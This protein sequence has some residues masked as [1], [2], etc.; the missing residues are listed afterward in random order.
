[1]IQEPRV[2]ISVP[3]P[4]LAADIA[5]LD[6]ADRVEC[7]T[8]DLTTPSPS[9][10]IELVVLP[11]QQDPRLV[12]NLGATTTQ[13]VQAQTIGY[14]DIVAHLPP[15]HTVAN[16]RSVH[17]ASTAEL[18]LG[19]ALASLRR[20]PEYSIAA[21]GGRWQQLPGQSL[22]DRTVA[23]VGYGGV[24]QAIEKRLDGF[25]ARVLRFARTARAGGPGGA[26]L[27]HPISSLRGLL[28][29]IDV[30]ILTVPLTEETRHLV[31]DAFLAAMRPG[32]LLV[33]VAR[34]PVVDTD[35]LV[36]ALETGHIRA[37]LDVTDPEPLPPEHPLWGLEG[38]LITPHVGGASSAMHPRMVALI[39]RQLRALLNGETPE[40]IV[41]SR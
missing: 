17:E 7:I 20:F 37:A 1:M 9:A 28:P 3:T 12:A 36:R 21:Q 6:L 26:R 35:A 25:E 34:G 19:L 15:G 2:S 27:V 32:A 39:E 11:Y 23:I 14:E 22:A 5:Q 8:W 16:A 10:H 18:A 4:A 33:N 41:A 38:V 13:L 29:E 31:D 24:G 30:V 40:N